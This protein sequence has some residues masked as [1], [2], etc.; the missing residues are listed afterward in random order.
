MHTQIHYIIRFGNHANK[1]NPVNL[2]QKQRG[3]N[4]VR[5]STVSS[6]VTV[7]DSIPLSSLRISKQIVIPLL[8]RYACSIAKLVS[9]FYGFSN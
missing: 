5:H 6:G 8:S 7:C 4:R 9:L 3:K 1:C 2:V